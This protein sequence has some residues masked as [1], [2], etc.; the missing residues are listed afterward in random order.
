MPLIIYRAA[1]ILARSVSSTKLR[2]MFQ[3]L[4]LIKHLCHRKWHVITIPYFYQ[5]I[6]QIISCCFENNKQD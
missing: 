6:F 1:S 4:L 3:Y 2:Y 5:F